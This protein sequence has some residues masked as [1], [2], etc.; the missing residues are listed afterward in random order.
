MSVLSVGV[1]PKSSVTGE[2]FLSNSLTKLFDI[3]TTFVTQGATATTESVVL[4][5]CYAIN[6]DASEYTFT[7]YW[8]STSSSD[9]KQLTANGMKITG[10]DVRPVPIT[11][12]TLPPG[13]SVWGVASVAN[14]IVVNF[15]YAAL[16]YIP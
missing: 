15:S 3:P 10:P 13:G 11:G 5:S 8:S 12:L 6:S 2:V 16:G 9:T 14:K 7:L 4:T 1:N